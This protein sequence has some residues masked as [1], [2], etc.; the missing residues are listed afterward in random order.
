MKCFAKKEKKIPDFFKIDN[1]VVTDRTSIA[2]IFNSF[3]TN[4]GP[5]LTKEIYITSRNNFKNYLL[6]QNDNNFTF[7]KILLAN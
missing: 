4:I 6:N 2:N 5:K 3:F 1:I 7:K